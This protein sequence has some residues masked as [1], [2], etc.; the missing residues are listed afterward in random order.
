MSRNVGMLP[1]IRKSYDNTRGANKNFLTLSMMKP[2]EILN[3]S[4]ANINCA[5]GD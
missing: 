5:T 3:K 4:F 1:G 2:K